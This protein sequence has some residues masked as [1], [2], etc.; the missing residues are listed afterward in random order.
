MVP[1][2]PQNVAI[3]TEVQCSLTTTVLELSKLTDMDKWA[4]P[5]IPEKGQLY[6]DYSC[7]VWKCRNRIRCSMIFDLF[8]LRGF[9]V[10]RHGRMDLTLNVEKAS[11]AVL[12]FRAGH[13]NE[14]TMTDVQ[15]SLTTTVFVVSN[16]HERLVATP[17]IGKSDTFSMLFRAGHEN[18]PIMTDTHSEINITWNKVL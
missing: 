12:M 13:Q 4:P 16:W 10:N 1:V 11:L 3:M 18:T 7:W 14:A 9:K 6:S 5:W 17:N 15:W 8:S 2:W